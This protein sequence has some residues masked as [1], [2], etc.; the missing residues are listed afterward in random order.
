MEKVGVALVT[1]RT[2]ILTYLVIVVIPATTGCQ[3]EDVSH[4][5]AVFVIRKL[6]FVWMVDVKYARSYHGYCH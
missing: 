4:R 1:C 2:T 6:I 3:M 5:G